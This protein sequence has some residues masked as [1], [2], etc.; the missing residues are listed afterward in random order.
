MGTIDV[1]LLRKNKRWDM[2]DRELFS[3]ACIIDLTMILGGPIDP[4][5]IH[6][7]CTKDFKGMFIPSKNASLTIILEI[8]TLLM[9][10]RMLHH[11]NPRYQNTMKD[12]FAAQHPN[13]LNPTFKCYNLDCR[14]CDGL[15][16]ARSFTENCYEAQHKEI[17]L[18]QSIG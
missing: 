3:S 2:Y 8:E 4:Q 7:T 12:D 11:D 6:H 17:T 16:L 15:A 1:R 13:Y 9:N 14:T 10:L 5:D 18:E